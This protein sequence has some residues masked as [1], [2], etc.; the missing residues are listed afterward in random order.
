[1][2]LAFVLFIIYA[3]I[4]GSFTLLGS[5]FSSEAGGRLKTNILD[6]IGLLWSFYALVGPTV[7]VALSY[8]GVEDIVSKISVLYSYDH[9]IWIMIAV[10]FILPIP[11]LA[12]NKIEERKIRR[13][14]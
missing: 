12:I 4:V 8:F 10:S 2:S 11:M 5:F 6:A 9:A 7:I 3:F 14:L 1:M 13:S